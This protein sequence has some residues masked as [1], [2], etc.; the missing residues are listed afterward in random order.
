MIEDGYGVSNLGENDLFVLVFPREVEEG[1]NNSDTDI[2]NFF[3][4]VSTISPLSSEYREYVDVFSES[5]ARQL[6]NHILVKYTIDTGDAES[7]YRFIYNLSA[8]ELSIFRDNLEEF[9]KKG[10]I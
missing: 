9:L 7:L 4:E 2:D 5:E 3:I 10:Y 8:N 6:S 1:N